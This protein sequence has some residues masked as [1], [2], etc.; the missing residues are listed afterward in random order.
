MPTIEIYEEESKGSQV[1]YMQ[2]T[3]HDKRSSHEI[4]MAANQG[5]WLIDNLENLK[6]GEGSIMTYG[7]LKSS[8]EESLDDFTLF[9]Y[10]DSM[11]AMREIGLLVL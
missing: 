1:E 11:T 5:Q 7:Q 9:W 6:I 8:Y 3:F 2:M 4:S 10:G